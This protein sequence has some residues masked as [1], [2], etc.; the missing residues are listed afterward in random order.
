MPGLA[1][2]HT[3]ISAR[4]VEFPEDIP[5]KVPV[6]KESFQKAN[7]LIKAWGLDNFREFLHREFTVRELEDHL[8]PLGIKITGENKDTKV[9]GSSV[10]GPKIGQGFYQN[11]SGNYN[12]V[13]FDLWW[14]RTWGRLIGD[15]VGSD[16]ELLAEQ[17]QRFVDALK[18]EGRPVPRTQEKLKAL[19][20][21]IEAAHEKDYAANSDLYKSKERIKSKVTNTAIRYVL[22][23]DGLKENPTSGN[24]RN[25]M[26]S[27]VADARQSLANDGIH[28]TNADM[29][30]ILWYPE[31]N[32][33]WKLGGPSVE[34]TN[35]DYSEA[36]Q[37]IAKQKGFTDEQ[38]L[39]SLGRGTGR[40]EGYPDIA[41]EGRRADTAAVVGRQ[42]GIERA[43]VPGGQAVPAARAAAQGLP[44]RGELSGSAGQLAAP[45]AAAQAR[46]RDTPLAGL[47]RQ[48]TIPGQGK[49][50]VGPSPA[51]RGVAE[52]H[53]RSAGLPYN[54]PQ[55][56]AKVDPQ[57]CR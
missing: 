27:V 43:E 48:V 46:G 39:Q 45:G 18:A 33:Y 55:T 16:P 21:Q 32:L 54:P 26:R 34:F 29:Q 11:L 42:Q 50:A 23:F 51:I 36:L 9:Y 17:R 19:A 1:K 47:P 12:P 25:W 4:Q 31:K 14:M 28:V 57:A 15:L 13:T 38:I 30:A 10:F 40:A 6:I 24:Q 8:A 7:E 20:E 37:K 53:I 44:R 22:G 3:I 5:T 56:Y 52:N 2:M 35:Q 49:I 41:N